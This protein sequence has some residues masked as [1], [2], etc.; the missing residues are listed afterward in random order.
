MLFIN[1]IRV[2]ESTGVEVPGV[3]EV[4]YY[5]DAP[6]HQEKNFKASKSK[7]GRVGGFVD[8]PEKVGDI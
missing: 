7:M 8:E 4:V 5:C 3:L 2:S 1:L 6:T